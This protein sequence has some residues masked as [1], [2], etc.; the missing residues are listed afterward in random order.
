VRTAVIGGTGIHWL[1]SKRC[2]LRKTRKTRKG[3]VD[4]TPVLDLR[5]VPQG[6]RQPPWCARR[7]EAVD[8][9]GAMLVGKGLDRF[10]LNDDP[11][12]S[13]FAYS[14]YFVV[15]SCRPTVLFHVNYPAV[16]TA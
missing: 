14:A 16:R 2:S 1:A 4:E 5:G 7:F 13:S 8:H 3:L 9:L 15:L 6:D 10:D 12:D 11:S